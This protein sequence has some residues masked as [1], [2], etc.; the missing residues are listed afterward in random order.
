VVLLTGAISSGLLASALSQDED[1]INAS[2]KGSAFLP[3]SAAELLK[4]AFDRSQP[5]P[6]ADTAIFGASMVRAGLFGLSQIENKELSDL[7]ELAFNG[8]SADE[9]NALNCIKVKIQAKE[10]LTKEDRTRFALVTKNALLS[11][12][13]E[14]LSRL[15]EINFQ[16][17]K[18]AVRARW[19]DLVPINPN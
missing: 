12:T 4:K 19:P 10:V 15:Q 14:K 7:W 5:A 6:G 8:L 2:L 18:L 16:A 13:S 17:L 11:L 9:K 3:D 1:L